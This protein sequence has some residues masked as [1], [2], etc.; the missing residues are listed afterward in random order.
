MTE[1][2]HRPWP[3]WVISF[4][5]G[6][7]LLASIYANVLGLTGHLSI[8][9]PAGDF[10]RELN[11]T[12]YLIALAGAIV[13]L[14]AAVSLFQLKRVAWPLFVIVFLSVP[15][16]EFYHWLTKPA[17]GAFFLQVGYL[18]LITGILVN[19]TVLVYVNR[20]RRRQV[21]GGQLP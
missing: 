13:G 5:F 18:A 14:V 11:T 6:L 21:L 3:V 4:Y 17:Y 12:D 15:A 10:E 16:I 1:H 9:G 19:G 7:S 20:L 2:R 8:P